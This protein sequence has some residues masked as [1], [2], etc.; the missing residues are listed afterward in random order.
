MF[1]PPNRHLLKRLLS[2]LV[3][4]RHRGRARSFD[5]PQNTMTLRAAGSLV[6]QCPL[7]RESLFGKARTRFDRSKTATYHLK[8]G[9]IT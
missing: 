4:R 2:P 5:D 1:D 9:Q 8:H 7:F 3:R 6:R